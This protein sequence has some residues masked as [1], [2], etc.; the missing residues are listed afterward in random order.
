MY[1]N[2]KKSLRHSFCSILR[3]E[4]NLQL[5]VRTMI[6][7][8]VSILINISSYYTPLQSRKASLKS[9]GENCLIQAIWLLDLDVTRRDATKWFNFNGT[10]ITWLQNRYNAFGAVADPPK[11]DS[12]LVATV[13]LT[14]S[15]TRYSNDI[16]TIFDIYTN[17]IPY[18]YDSDIQSCR[19][20]IQMRNSNL[21]GLS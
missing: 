4:Q 1:N 2:K 10:T 11:Y 16:R 17:V 5:S 19:K 14:F 13:P 7:R 15:F 21:A 9:I 6:T 3:N 8:C 20:W 12:P 18:T